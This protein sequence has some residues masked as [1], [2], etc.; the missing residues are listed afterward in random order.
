MSVLA[1]QKSACDYDV[2]VKRGDCKVVFHC[3]HDLLIR[4]VLNEEASTVIPLGE[5][6]FIICFQF[7]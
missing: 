7:N 6:N 2:A 5:K 3:V 4:Y 1:G